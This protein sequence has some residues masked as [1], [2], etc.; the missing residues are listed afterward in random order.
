[1]RSVA[2]DRHRV[3]RREPGRRAFELADLREDAR[4]RRE[5][6]K[7]VLLRDDVDEAR[8]RRT[9]VS[10]GTIARRASVFAAE[11]AGGAGAVA[12]CLPLRAATELR[13]NETD[14]HA[15]DRE[16]D[17]ADT[18]I[19]GEAHDGGRL[20]NDVPRCWNPASLSSRECTSRSLDDTLRPP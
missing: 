3:R 4:V 15:G 9:A 10:A 6:V 7:L 14:P 8:G 2:I 18:G 12:E 1:G 16:A 11:A 20:A 5:A 19:K 13:G 17:D